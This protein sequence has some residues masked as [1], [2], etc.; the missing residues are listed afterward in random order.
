[1]RR[2]K[3]DRFA[4]KRD[5]QR[6]DIP[7]RVRNG[8]VVLEGDAALPE[9]TEVTVTTRAKAVIRVAKN[10]KRVEFPLVHSITPGTVHV[11]NEMI[12]QILDEEDASS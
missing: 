4:A 9:G 10:Q 8:V 11:T 1:L 7:G 3:L 2:S 6:M 12:G 5:N